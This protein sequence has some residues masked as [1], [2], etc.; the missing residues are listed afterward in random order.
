M[1]RIPSLVPGSSAWLQSR[2]ASKA[3]AMMG[4]DPKTS[5]NELLRMM[6]TG[7]GKE[8]SEWAQKNLLDKGKE[9][10]VGGLDI[11]EDVLND[12][13]SPV[14]GATDDDYLTAAPDGAN[15]AGNI[16]VE[17]KAWNEK[18][19]AFVRDS[20]VPPYHAW[21]LDQQILVFGFDYILFCVTDGTREKFVSME[22][23]STPE[24]AA[25]LLAGWKQ[26]DI[27]LANYQHIEHPPAIVAA[28]ID[29]LPALTVELV[30]QVTSS[31]LALFK[32]AAL[33]RIESINTNLQT[34]EDFAVAKKTVKFLDDGEKR[35]VLVKQ[36]ALSQTASIDELFRTM[37]AL[38]E[39]MK[40][41]R[42]TLDKLVTAREASIKI[43]IM[44]AGKDALAAH[45]AT[46][47]KR[48]ATVQMPLI[49]A[50]F[51]TV[52]K[53]KRNL[54]SMRG[55]VDDLVAEKKIE[56]NALADQMQININTLDAHKEHQF[57]FP[58]IQQIITKPNDY[59]ALLV[60]SRIDAEDKRKAD[61]RER[62]RREEEAKAKAEAEA[63]LLTEQKKAEQ[64]RL[65]VERER[66]RQEEAEKL[67]KAA[68]VIAEPVRAESIAPP[69]SATE[70]PKSA[71]PMTD[72]EMRKECNRILWGLP[73][74]EI[75]GLYRFMVGLVARKEQE[76]A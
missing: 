52:I 70:L 39:E 38:R 23:R 18:T 55:A 11:A 20:I 66:I 5:R 48:L 71:T 69:A 7:V 59:F 9:V 74:Q 75:P 27:D 16:G 41:K 68:Q 36:Q 67:Q 3:P 22:Y 58:D 56:S 73:H 57:L 35:L 2:S 32:S 51:A 6:A 14:C 46:L 31:N 44:Q 47:N 4:D 8:F 17:I 24:R 34:D 62:I 64:E 28:P 63:K 26:F 33:A 45:I 25:K 29:D 76:A 60:K 13:L 21:Q 49:L 40:A 15:F 65:E 30:G 19:A 61:E 54:E 53:G 43:E 50:D 10:E 72:T 12:S 1:K 37:D 42:L